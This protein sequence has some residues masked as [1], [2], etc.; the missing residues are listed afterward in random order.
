LELGAGLGSS[1]GGWDVS[2]GCSQTGRGAVGGNFILV[3]HVVLFIVEGVV[4]IGISH[5]FVTKVVEI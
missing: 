5:L 2:F 4:S 1:V 3:T